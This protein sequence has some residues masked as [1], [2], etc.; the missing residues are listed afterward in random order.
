[1]ARPAMAPTKN[2]PP[3]VLAAVLVILLSAVAASGCG[4]ESAQD[5]PVTLTVTRDFGAERLGGGAM[6]VPEGETAM[7]LLQRDFDVKTANGGSVVRSI[8]GIAGGRA[9][10]RPS[11][12]F[13][14]VNGVAAARGPAEQK[15]QGGDRV[16]WD[17][18]DRDLIERVPSVV[19]SFPQPFSS[20]ADGRRQP[21]RVECAEGSTRECDEVTERLEQE[22]VKRTARSTIGQAQENEVLRV[23][24]GPWTKVRQ[25]PATV[26]IEKGPRASGIFARFDRAGRRL[27]VLDPRGRVVRPLGR[28]AGLVAATS[29]EGGAPVWVVTGTDQVGVAAAAAGLQEAMLRNH[30]AIAVEEGRAVP[31]PITEEPR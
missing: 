1:M 28:G 10:D 9:A 17:H 22:G 12:W 19:G 20:G 18:H 30:F 24:V 7:Q 11:G 31:L 6:G 26:R 21:V 2:R 13:Y 14:Y 23:L 3:A 25:D 27:D 4:G 8:G 16:W 15:V 5:E 29:L